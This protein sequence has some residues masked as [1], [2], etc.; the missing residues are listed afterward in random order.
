MGW[1]DQPDPF[2]QLT[3]P[4]SDR[5][6]VTDRER[7][8]LRVR[9]EEA[10]PQ[11]VRGDHGDHKVGDETFEKLNEQE[12]HDR[13]IGK[14]GFAGTRINS[15]YGAQ[16]DVPQLKPEELNEAVDL[17][18][19]DARMKA[20][21]KLTQNGANPL[22]TDS[23]MQCGASAMLGAAMYGGGND[24]IKS[25]L[26]AMMADHAQDKIVD[27]DAKAPWMDE[28]FKKLVAKLDQPN[29]QLTR[30][31]LATIQSKTYQ[32]F[33]AEKLA[34]KKDNDPSD[35]ANGGL[36]G[37]KLNDFVGRHKD[38]Q[39]MFKDND[40][41][42]DS[43]DLEGT[44]TGGHLVLGIGHHHDMMGSGETTRDTIFDPQARQDKRDWG[45]FMSS[46]T[47]DKIRWD[48]RAAMQA[49]F[50][51]LKSIDTSNP[52]GRSVWAGKYDQ[53]QQQLQERIH[54]RQF[55]Y[56]ADSQL[57]TDQHELNDYRKA[58]AY[59]ANGDSKLK[60]HKSQT[61]PENPFGWMF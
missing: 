49:D 36:V 16:T 26:H 35:P 6:M 19:K 28:D 58:T 18:S 48:E 39:K 46:D 61:K 31:D 52:A 22:E 9:F 14:V 44:G 37:G 13:I 59:E 34:G 55:A 4:Y 51:K 54:T 2:Q 27:K 29:A 11:V 56:K 32:H 1:F 38:I 47:L 17:S 40:M 60:T 45:D 3:D 25:L 24:G 10:Q 7:E 50:D 21:S 23:A 30:G 57:I 42:L 33:Q 15:H 5:R 8:Q 43:I 41:G 12:I 20:L 53:L